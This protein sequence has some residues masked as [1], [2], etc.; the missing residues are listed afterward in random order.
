M[1]SQ[2]SRKNVQLY[3]A[4]DTVSMSPHKAQ[5]RCPGSRDFNLSLALILDHR[6]SQMN[7]LLLCGNI[8]SFN[9]RHTSWGWRP[10]AS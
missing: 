6:L 5:F 3:K 9:K 8:N 10:E 4:R 1:V 2:A 7:S